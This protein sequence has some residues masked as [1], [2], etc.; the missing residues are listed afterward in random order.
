MIV[1]TFQVIKIKSMFIITWRFMFVIIKII[2]V[3]A[4]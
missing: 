4:A 2:H 3:P 1:S